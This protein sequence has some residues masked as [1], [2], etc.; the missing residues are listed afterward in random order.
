[1]WI[2]YNVNYITHY[3]QSTIHKGQITAYIDWQ[4]ICDWSSGSGV[5]RKKEPVSRGSGGGQRPRSWRCFLAEDGK[6]SCLVTAPSCFRCTI[7]G[8]WKRLKV[9]QPALIIFLNTFDLKNVQHIRNSYI[10]WYNDP[11][12]LRLH[13]TRKDYKTRGINRKCK[14]NNLDKIRINNKNNETNKGLK[15]I[16]VARPQ[17]QTRYIQAIAC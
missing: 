4:Y 3:N 9:S 17:Q 11:V 15:Q 1:M 13:G 6:N 16:W 2:A 8:E 14:S 12:E 7:T 10:H 5:A